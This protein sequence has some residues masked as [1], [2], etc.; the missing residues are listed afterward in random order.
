[1]KK[2]ETEWLGNVEQTSAGSNLQNLIDCCRCFCLWV[3]E[4]YQTNFVCQNYEDDVSSSAMGLLPV[5]APNSLRNFYVPVVTDIEDGGR[6]CPGLCPAS[7]VSK[8]RFR[9]AGGNLITDKYFSQWWGNIFKNFAW[10]FLKI[11]K[12]ITPYFS[13]GF[14]R[15]HLVW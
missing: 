11:N 3:C 14:L 8:H 7:L 4:T 10:L 13:V 2:L 12:R 5:A 9:S 1:M 15:Y 6:S